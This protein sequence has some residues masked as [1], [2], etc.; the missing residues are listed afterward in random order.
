M[1]ND[2]VLRIFMIEDDRIRNFLV[3]LLMLTGLAKR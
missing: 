3:K 2:L 1:K